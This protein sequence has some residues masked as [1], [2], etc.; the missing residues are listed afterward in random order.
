MSHIDRIR[1]MHSLLLQRYGDLGWWPAETPDEVVIGT[2]LTQNTT[3]T[4]VEKCIVNLKE[5]NKCSLE[6]I[7][8]M[9]PGEL[10][11]LIKSSGFYNQKAERLIDLSRKII[12]RYSTLEKMSEQLLEDLETFLGSIKGVGRE[13]MDSILAYALNKPVFVVDKY[14]MRIFSRVGM[15]KNFP[16]IESVKNAVEE[17]VGNDGDVLRN[18][19]G[20]LVYLGKDYCR[21]KPLCRNCPV[22]SICN[23]YAT[24]GP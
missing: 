7:S 11:P 24:E 21:T 13:T 22:N 19:H 1:E 3:W 14:T 20:L 12:G 2:I 23:F 5:K 10:A 17:S 16:D 9:D 6:A 18:I 8:E 4:S 15:E